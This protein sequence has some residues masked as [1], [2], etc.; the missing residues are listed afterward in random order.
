MN[1]R[2]IVIRTVDTR[3]EQYSGVSWELHSS[4]RPNESAI[5]IKARDSTFLDNPYGS[6]RNVFKGLLHRRVPDV[7]A[8]L[9]V[10][11]E[12]DSQV[13]LDLELSKNA[14]AIISTK[15]RE[16]IWTENKRSAGQRIL[17][18]TPP[19]STLLTIGLGY[20]LV[21]IRNNHLAEYNAT[22]QALFYSQ[23]EEPSTRS[24]KI[25]DAL[26]DIYQAEIAQQQ[27]NSAYI[28]A[29]LIDIQIRQ[30]PVNPEAKERVV[31]SAV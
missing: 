18:T 3:G 13:N 30:Q 28:L 22:I 7:G 26:R 25:L 4:A 8:S 2:R 14:S 16:T 20:D 6:V 11:T 31:G 5:I 15:D 10:T 19:L 1:E 23:F 21:A 27:A 9:I 12:M 24:A 17:H 29:A